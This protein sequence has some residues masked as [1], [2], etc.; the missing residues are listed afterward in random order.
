MLGRQVASKYSEKPYCPVSDEVIKDIE[1]NSDFIIANMESPILLHSNDVL[2]HMCFQGNPDLLQHFKWINLFSTANNHI[3]DFG[4]DGIIDTI[5]SLSEVGCLSNGV[6]KEEYTPVLIEQEKIAIVTLTDLMNKELSASSPYKLLRMD[7]EKTLDVITNYHN[8][9]YFVIVFAH[10]GMLF[11]RFPNPITRDY[12]HKFVDSGANII[13]T[14]HSHCVGGIE[15]YRSVP[16]IHSLGDFLMD[17]TSYRR[18]QS[19]YLTFE[20]NDNNVSSLSLHPL[21]TSTDLIT[22]YPPR[23]MKEAMESSIKY[24]SYKLEKI[25]NPTEYKH[26]FSKQY[27]KEILF[28]SWSTILF[29]IKTKGIKELFRLLMLRKEDVKH[30][31]KWGTSDRSDVQSDTE[32]LDIKTKLTEDQI[33]GN[34]GDDNSTIL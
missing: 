28:H 8:R 20:V 12:L 25:K 2:D 33:F 34:R 1:I 17:G 22:S 13:V 3:N 19:C 29:I 26:F 23:K 24:V 31:I 18:R 15:Y 10:V 32:A 9:G 14:S 7:S 6:Y 16:I 11:T 4:D 27:K 5:Y 30:L 21:F